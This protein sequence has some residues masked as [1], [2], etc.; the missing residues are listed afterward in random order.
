MCPFLGGG[1]SFLLSNPCTCSGRFDAEDVDLM[2][3][4]T[5]DIMCLMHRITYDPASPRLAT[6]KPL[7]PMYR[8]TSLIRDT[9]LL[10]P[11]SR[12][13]PHPSYDPTVELCHTP[14]TTLQ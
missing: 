9:L 8:G 3:L 13:V 1:V 5:S 10:R 4:D 14:L 6:T 2:G 11:Y 7:W 12:P